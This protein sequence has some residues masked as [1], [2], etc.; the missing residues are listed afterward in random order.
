MRRQEKLS[1][2]EENLVIGNN[3]YISPNMHKEQTYFER[4]GHQSNQC[5]MEGTK[6]QKHTTD[7]V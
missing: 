6:G 2:L 3:F 1:F 4:I 5:K 7:F